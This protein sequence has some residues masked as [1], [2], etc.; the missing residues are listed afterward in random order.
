MAGRVLKPLGVAVD[1]YE[2]GN[3]M[4]K[5]GGIGQNTKEVAKDAAISWGS[6]AAGAAVGAGIG[7][8]VPVLGTGVGAVV[9]GIVGGLA[10]DAVSFVKGLFG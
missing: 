7:S 10:P 1:A 8:V 4:Y 2:L 3:A 6:A 9:G 5:D